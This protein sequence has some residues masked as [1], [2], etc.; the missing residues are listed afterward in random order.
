MLVSR[1]ILSARYPD[2]W[3]ELLTCLLE[4]C[5]DISCGKISDLSRKRA[6]LHRTVR[7][8]CAIVLLQSQYTGVSTISFAA[9]PFLAGLQSLLASFLAASL[10]K[11]LKIERQAGRLR[12]TA[13]M[14]VLRT[15]HTSS[16]SL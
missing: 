6:A 13:D 15:H 5:F 4:E 12:V 2:S 11:F 10:R 1:T 9:H 8:R 16:R 7:V 3:S 14:P